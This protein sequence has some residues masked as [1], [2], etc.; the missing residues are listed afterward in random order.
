MSG[1]G[2]GQSGAA[3]G[4]GQ[5]GAASAGAGG[6]AEGVTEAR[7]NEILNIALSKRFRDFKSEQTKA[8]E[9][10]KNSIIEAIGDKLGETLDESLSSKLQELGVKPSSGDGKK[11]GAQ[12]SQEEIE[13]HPAFRSLKKKLETQ[14]QRFAKMEA[15]K[16]AERDKAR[17]ATLRTSLLESL[18]KQ[19]LDPK[20]AG[21]AADGLLHRKVVRYLDEDSDDIVFVGDDGGELDLATG[22]ETWAKSEDGKIFI[23]PSGA[24][25]SGGSGG[26]GGQRSRVPNGQGD[27]PRGMLGNM[28]IQETF[29]GGKSP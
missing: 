8:L 21:N 16:K 15:E 14:D 4:D 23:P 28:I 29:G 7:V 26:G 1:E 13:N 12:L 27:A 6:T 9:D 5:G 18:G 20:R 3:S 10:T 2:E 19:G 17:D 22:V 25:G 11:S 24:S